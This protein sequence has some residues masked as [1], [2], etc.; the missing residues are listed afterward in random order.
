MKY[1][2]KEIVF[3]CPLRC[4]VEGGKTG[5]HKDEEVPLR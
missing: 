3:A 4:A 1:L 5:A 2:G